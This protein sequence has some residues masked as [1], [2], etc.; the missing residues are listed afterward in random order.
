MHFTS[1]LLSCWYICVG[2][3]EVQEDSLI[4]IHV[5]HRSEHF[6]TSLS[7]MF[8]SP[9][10][11]VSIIQLSNQPKPIY[12]P[13][14]VW[15]QLHKSSPLLFTFV[16]QGG[17]WIFRPSEPWFKPCVLQTS[18]LLMNMMIFLWR[19]QTC[20]SKVIKYYF[21]LFTYNIVYEGVQYNSVCCWYCPDLQ[22]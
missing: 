21:C 8:F 4:W 17:C 3:P 7:K 1:V 14:W 12:A 6:N 22:S 18:A 5:S 13:C 20:F 2:G 19:S 10:R 11:I 16:Q 9:E 15:Y